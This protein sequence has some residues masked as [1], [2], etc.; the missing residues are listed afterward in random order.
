MIVL[1]KPCLICFPFS[2]AFPGLFKKKNY[3]KPRKRPMKSKLIH[4][5]LLDKMTERTPKTGEEMVLLQAGLGRRTIEIPEDADHSEIS[6]LLIQSFP[7]MAALDGAWLLYKAAGGSG[8]RKLN[9]VSPEAEGYSGAHLA[10]SFPGCLR[11]SASTVRSMYLCSCCHFTLKG[12][13]KLSMTVTQFVKLP[14]IHVRF[15]PSVMCHT[16]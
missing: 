16:L 1:Q 13:R 15:A 2:R 11:Q 7:K 5:F 12:V 10:K 3:I 14:M 8:Q 4:F 9:V 6:A